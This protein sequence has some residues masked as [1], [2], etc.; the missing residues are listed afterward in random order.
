MRKIQFTNNEYYHIFNRGVDKREIFL[1]HGDLSRFFQSME[2]FNTVNPIG[3]IFE[4]SFRKLGNPVSKLEKLV[5]FVCY[6]LN[7]NHYHFILEQLSD[8]GIEKFMHRLGIGYTKYFNKKHDR[9]GALFQGNYKAVH[10]NSNEYLLHVSAYVNLNNKVHSLG[11][12]VS[13]LRLSKSSWD[14][15]INN[16][17]GFCKKDIVLGQFNNPNEYK[18][19]AE[20][21][22]VDIKERKETKELLL[23]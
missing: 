3:S 16:Q 8:N 15:Y 6:C 1:D 23:E 20:S 5:N 4:N 22:L 11:N 21:S 13:K 18:E 7:L 19:F 12:P 9:V 17:I 2:E 10:I 14:E